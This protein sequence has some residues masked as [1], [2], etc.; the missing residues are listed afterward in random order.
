VKPAPVGDRGSVGAHGGFSRGIERE[1]SR[2]LIFQNRLVLAENHLLEMRKTDI[3]AFVID[4][5]M[6][7]V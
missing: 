5:N 7:F 6:S 4:Q 3:G 1:T 2:A